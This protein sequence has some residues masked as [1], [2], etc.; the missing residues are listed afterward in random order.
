MALF[1]ICIFLKEDTLTCRMGERQTDT[2]RKRD[3]ENESR[4][5]ERSYL[6]NLPVRTL[7]KE[8]IIYP[9]TWKQFE[10]LE[11]KVN[12]GLMSIYKYITEHIFHLSYYSKLM[13]SPFHQ[14]SSTC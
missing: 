2:A 14:G 9:S 10:F 13:S 3:R 6:T 5:K 4:I 11:L 7:F 8:F 1:L 12:A